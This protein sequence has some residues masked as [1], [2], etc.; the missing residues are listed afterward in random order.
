ME[1]TRNSVANTKKLFAEFNFWTWLSS[2][3]AQRPERAL[4]QMA[5]EIDERGGNKV[6]VDLA[7]AIADLNAHWDF[8]N[9]DGKV[10][11]RQK[12]EEILQQLNSAF[13][14]EVAAFALKLMLPVAIFQLLGVLVMFALPFLR[15]LGR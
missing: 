9:G 1:S 4:F 7:E 5:L 11:A 3:P 10:L 2:H 6:E 14:S 13:Q 8:V 15:E 12:R